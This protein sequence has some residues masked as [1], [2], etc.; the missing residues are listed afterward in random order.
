MC[1]PKYSTNID[2]DRDDHCSIVFNGKPIII[3]TKC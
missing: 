2:N 1:I 3:K